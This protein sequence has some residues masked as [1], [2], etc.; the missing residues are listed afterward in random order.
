MLINS[1]KEINP[2]KE[3]ITS[4]KKI[5]FVN[6]NIHENFSENSIKMQISEESQQRK[7]NTKKKVKNFNFFIML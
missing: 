3:I 1:T 5:H 2:S 7:E 6:Q 4:E